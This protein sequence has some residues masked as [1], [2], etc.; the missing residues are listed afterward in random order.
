MKKSKPKI[1][2]KNAV[3]RKKGFL[4]YIDGVGNICEAKM[5][6]GRKRKEKE[7]D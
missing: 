5:K 2:L 4:Y 3:E 1:I 7:D 6:H